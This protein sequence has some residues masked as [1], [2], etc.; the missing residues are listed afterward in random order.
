MVT[1]R[2]SRTETP[3]RFSQLLLQ[4]CDQQ[5][6]GGAYWATLTAFAV[7][8][9]PLL[10]RR[11]RPVCVAVLA[12]QLPVLKELRQAPV[13]TL[14]VLVRMRLFQRGTL[15]SCSTPINTLGSNC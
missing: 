5:P 13:T 15:T 7:P 6:G 3:E 4:G 2:A 8:W 11:R 9:P 14:D 1:R 12:A 10:Q